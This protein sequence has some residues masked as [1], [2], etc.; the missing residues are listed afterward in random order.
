MSSC[1]SMCFTLKKTALRPVSPWEQ[2]EPNRCAFPNLLSVSSV[3]YEFGSVLKP[4]QCDSVFFCSTVCVT[5]GKP[6]LGQR[7]IVIKPIC[8]LTPSCV[9]C[10][11]SQN[12]ALRY[13]WVC[14]MVFSQQHQ[15]QQ[16]QQREQHKP[17]AERRRTGIQHHLQSAA[18]DI[19]SMA[20]N[21]VPLT[22]GREYLSSSW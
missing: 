2:T 11:E 21:T 5:K 19:T 17:I 12:R 6:Y 1:L 18:H 10:C 4:A 13:L 9:Y 15:Q 3:C 16:Q 7:D 8:A 22:T 20:I 14:L